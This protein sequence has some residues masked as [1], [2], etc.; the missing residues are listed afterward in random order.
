MK[1]KYIPIIL[2]LFSQFLF[3]QNTFDIILNGDNRE[4]DCKQ[5]IETFRQ[6]PKGVRFSIEREGNN[7]YFQVNDKKWFE[8]LFNKSGDGIA[9]DVVLKKRY[10]CGLG[11]VASSQ[12]KGELLEPV[13]AKALK[14]GLKPYA[15]DLFRVKIG[16]IPEAYLNQKSEFNILFLSNKTLCQYYVIYELESYQWELLDMGMYLDSLTY[17]PKKVQSSESKSTLIRN[18]IL[19]FDIPFQKNKSNYSQQDIKPIYDSLRLTDF[20]IK[21][22]KVKSYSSIEGITTRNLELQELRANSIISALQKFQKPTI[23]TTVS[24]AENWVEF[25]NDIKGTKYE[26]LL[27]LTKNDIKDAIAGKLSRDM[28]SILKHHRKAVLEMELEKIYEYKGVSPKEL[29]INF[30]TAVRLNQEAAARRIQNSIFEKIKSGEVTSDILSQ[31]A[32][33]MSD[34]YVQIRN[35]NAAFRY[36]LD[37]REVLLVYNEM[38]ELEKLMP[39][40]KKIK[41]NVA[42][43][44]LQLWRYNAIEINEDALEKQI[45]DLKQYGIG[46]DLITRMIVNFNIIRAE[47]LMRNRDYKNK[48]KAV[49]FIKD[50]YDKFSL[51]EYD[52]LSL[53]QFFSY[54]AKTEFSVD[55]LENKARSIYIDENLLFYFLNLTIIRNEFVKDVDYRTILLNAININKP[56]FCK[57]FEA[58]EDGGVTFQILD[59]N[60]LRAVYC[61]NCN[62]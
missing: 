9:I 54:Y 17:N 6:K 26:Y 48:D 27:S 52:Y 35:N 47:N 38:L 50:H 55:L 19:K 31:M 62:D 16:T 46:D 28:E 58:I 53:A 61:E 30:N 34:K 5:C 42:V 49:T 1:G 59:N 3:A 10:A 33:P 15:D 36:M 24:T 41:Y 51:S 23:Q 14:A 29:L 32:V 25:L 22:I 44:K 11:S 2:I 39:N 40:S 60:Y 45:Y 20:N 43:L 4:K 13:Y 21:T 12:I 8:T 18:K 56:R 7:L 37:F 57:L